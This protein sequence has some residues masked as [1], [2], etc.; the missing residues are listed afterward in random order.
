MSLRLRCASRFLDPEASCFR[1]HVRAQLTREV[2]LNTCRMNAENEH[3]IDLGL[4]GPEGDVLVKS[5]RSSPFGLQNVTNQIDSF[6][7]EPA[8]HAK[9]AAAT[10][11]SNVHGSSP[12]TNEGLDGQNKSISV[13]SGG[14]MS[15]HALAQPPSG[16][17]AVTDHRICAASHFCHPC[18]VR[19]D[20]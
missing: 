1:N 9:P 11:M 18:R 12:L 2:S 6:S 13:Y 4:P 15:K 19:Y 8:Q 3:V 20:L 7:L 10:F 14:I 16:A 5:A 17:H